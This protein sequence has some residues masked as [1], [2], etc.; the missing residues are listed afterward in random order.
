MR[1]GSLAAVR[2]RREVQIAGI[3]AA[4]ILPGQLS[5]MSGCDQFLYGFNSILVANP[6]APGNLRVAGKAGAGLLGQMQINDRGDRLC[7]V[8]NGAV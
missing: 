6:S 2:P 3:K 4:L 8:P 1:R 5:Q 7:A